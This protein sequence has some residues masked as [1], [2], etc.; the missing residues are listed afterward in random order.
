LITRFAPTPSGYLH[1]GNVFSFLVT[2]LIARQNEGKILL[3]IDDL[4]A[5]R[6]RPAYIEN[7]FR[8]LDWLGLDYDIGPAGVA[9]FQAN[10]SQHL[11]M[12][13]YQTAL[14]ELQASG[15]LFGCTCSRKDTQRDTPDGIYSGKCRNRSFKWKVE[16]TGRLKTESIDFICFED[17][18]LGQTHFTSNPAMVDPVVWRKDDLPAYHLASVV[19]DDHFAVDLVVRGVDLLEAT[20]A[21]LIIASH[22]K[23]NSFVQ[24]HFLHHPLIKSDSF[25]K[26][27]KSQ[28]SPSLFDRFD[29][30]QEV[31][32]KFGSILGLDN[33]QSDSLDALLENFNPDD[34]KK[35]KNSNTPC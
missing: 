3:R 26:L 31:F 12:D 35:C 29:A 28:K 30:A 32:I 1:F 25:Q 6:V 15:R 20:G 8:T 2:W 13:L 4:D 21:Q 23:K 34:L 10:F 17:R 11:R 16:T 27:S 19:D 33:D 22:L 24:N 14:K 5:D 18:L 7:L 9:D